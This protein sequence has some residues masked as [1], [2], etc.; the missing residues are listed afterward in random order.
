MPG[1]SC[2]SQGIKVHQDTA[3]SL[4]N[5]GRTG[6]TIIDQLLMK[7]VNSRGTVWIR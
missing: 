3:D 6:T 1:Y 2:K 5:G 4:D 7:I